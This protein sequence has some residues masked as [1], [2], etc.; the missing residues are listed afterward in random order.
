MILSNLQSVPIFIHS[1]KLIHFPRPPAR[2]TNP[3]FFPLISKPVHF[4]SGMM[5]H[6]VFVL[7]LIKFSLKP[8]Q[9]DLLG[10]ST[11]LNWR[12][13]SPFAEL[14]GIF[15][16]TTNSTFEGKLVNFSID[17]PIKVISGTL[18]VENKN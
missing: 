14:S 6:R 18:T 7:E 3:L 9:Q 2:I 8:P 1:P 5:P 16:F 12:G 4:L 11:Q 10:L 15:S 13:S 17:A